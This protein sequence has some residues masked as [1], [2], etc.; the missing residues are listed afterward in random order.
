MLFIFAQ[1]A[2]HGFGIALL[3]FDFEGDQVEQGAL[4]GLLF[5]NARQFGEDFLLLAAAEW[6][7]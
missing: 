1:A 5:P 3:V 6:R 4:F 2:Q 7:S